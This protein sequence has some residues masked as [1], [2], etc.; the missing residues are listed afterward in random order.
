MVASKDGL[1]AQRV[2]SVG[3]AGEQ[4]LVQARD[5]FVGRVREIA[6]DFLLD[7]AALLGP[8]LLRVL[9]ILHAGGIHAQ[10]RLPDPARER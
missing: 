4:I 5:E 7:R 8:L 2:V 3:R 10:G 9:D 1:R 6:R